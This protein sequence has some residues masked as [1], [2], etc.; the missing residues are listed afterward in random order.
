MGEAVLGVL[1]FVPMLLIIILANLADKRR[2]AGGFGKRFAGLSYASLIF[3]YGSIAILLGV[4]VQDHTPGVGSDQELPQNNTVWAFGIWSAAA[5][6]T[7]LLLPA[8]RRILA[9]LVPI[10]YRSSVHAIAICFVMLPV[11]LRAFDYASGLGTEADL[12][13]A[14][15]TSVAATLTSFLI[16]RFQLAVLT[17]VGAGWLIRRTWRQVLVR[18]G[19]VKPRPTE[20]AIGIGTGLLLIGIVL[21][22]ETLRAAAGW[23]LNGEAA[24]L[25]KAEYWYLYE[26]IPATL[27]AG[28]AL[29]IGREALFRGAL[30]PKFG[31]LLTSLLYV[32]VGAGPTESITLLGLTSTF[33]AGV[34]LGVLRMRFNT[35][36][37]VIALCT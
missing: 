19:L 11:I 10:D 2:L 20:I 32:V 21:I 6:A 13:E 26:S 27:T 8:A 29:G 28:I 7:F 4:I 34:V 5:T 24:R 23:E 16:Q 30:Q 18:L 1:S 25:Q 9:G 17:L 3:F 22:L 35:T 14:S 31:L 37:G 33:I 36:T 15:Q 12:G